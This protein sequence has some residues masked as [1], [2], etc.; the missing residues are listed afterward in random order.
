[1]KNALSLCTISGSIYKGEEGR[2]CHG[3]KK[4]SQYE[5]LECAK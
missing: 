1:M 2:G 3:F 4:H 5:R